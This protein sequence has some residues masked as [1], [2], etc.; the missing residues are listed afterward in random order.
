VRVLRDGEAS[1]VPATEVVPGDVVALDAG[2]RIPADGR[3]VEA[4]T[5]RVEE[6]ALTGESAPA[7][8]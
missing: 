1:E 7:D 2:A 8:K 6:S 4:H 5:M 3:L